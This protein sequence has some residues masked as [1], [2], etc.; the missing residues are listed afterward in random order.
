MSIN[1]I[2]YF[3]EL[4][5]YGEVVC[6]HEANIRSKKMSMKMNM[7][8]CTNKAYYRCD[9]AGPFSA[10]VKYLCGVHSKNIANRLKLPPMSMAQKYELDQEQFEKMMT[11]ATQHALE[12]NEPGRVSLFKMSGMFPKVSPELGW[13]DV[14][15]NFKKNWQLI[16]LVCP[17]LSPMSLG[18]VHHNQPNLPP[19]KNIENFYQQ[20]KKF[21]CETESSFKQLQIKGFLDPIPHRRK[22]P[23]N[24]EEFD[25][26]AWMNKTGELLKFNLVEARYFYCTFYEKLVLLQ[27]K[28]HELKEF[29]D[30]KYKLRICGP[31]AFEM[32]QETIDSSYLD[33]THSFGHERCLFTMLTAPSCDWPWR[34]HA[35]DNVS[36][37]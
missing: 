36:I 23:K 21:K 28:F 30:K 7:K 5:K 2:Q 15:P 18:P 8:K 6:Q 32:K 35:L 27:P 29:I 4:P 17:E 22:Y 12:S 3:T 34:K 20:S 10:N 26:F 14:Y 9:N 1:A 16:G 25:Y 37:G 11:S 33:P 24:S 13:L 31:D 19:A